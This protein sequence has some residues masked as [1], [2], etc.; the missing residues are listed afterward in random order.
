MEPPS[1][2]TTPTTQ[3][4]SGGSKLENHIAAPRLTNHDDRTVERSSNHGIEIGD[5]RIEIKTVV[6]LVGLTVTSLIDGCAGMPGLRQSH[7]DAIPK[8]GVRRQTV[9]Q[10]E[11]NLVAACSQNHPQAR[12]ILRRNATTGIDPRRRKLAIPGGSA[13]DGSF[14]R[15]GYRGASAHPNTTAGAAQDRQ[16]P[17]HPARGS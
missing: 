2:H 5:E 9:H 17:I 8:P 14:M 1:T 10:Q 3:P 15:A 16:P 13:P 6:D 4:W 11:G 12:S 7:S